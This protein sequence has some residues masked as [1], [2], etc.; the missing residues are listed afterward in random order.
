MNIQNM[1]TPIYDFV[2]NY[3]NSDF[4]RFHMPGH[5][6]RDFTGFEKF[7]I[8]E[9]DGA[10]VLYMANG[11]I[12]ESEDNASS[13]FCTAKTFYSTEGS[14]HAI[15]A[16]LGAVATLKKGKRPFVLA[17]R[18]VHKAFIYAATLLAKRDEYKNK[19]IAVILPDTG[20]RYL[21]TELYNL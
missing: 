11:I 6:G 1:K 12:K 5:K 2:Q 13:L 21:S 17:S 20:D 19:R 18:N 16:M 3:A 8:T 15:R 4:S 14:S 7:D 10:D 9:I